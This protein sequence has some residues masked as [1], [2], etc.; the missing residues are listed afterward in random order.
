MD[1]FEWAHSSK[2]TM[3]SESSYGLNTPQLDMVEDEVDHKILDSDSK[4][5][6]PSLYLFVCGSE[7]KSAHMQLEF[8]TDCRTLETQ[9]VVLENAGSVAYHFEWFRDD[10]VADTDVLH[11][12]KDN[13]EQSCVHGVVHRTFISCMH[14]LLLPDECIEFT[15]F[16]RASTPGMYLEN[17]SLTLDPP[18]VREVHDSTNTK[19]PLKTS[20]SDQDYTILGV[21][22]CCI[23]VD[24]DVPIK[25]RQRLRD[26]IDGRATM[27]MAQQLIYQI[28]DSIKY[29]ESSGA[30]TAGST[31]A[32]V[33]FQTEHRN[34]PYESWYCYEDVANKAKSIN[35]AIRHLHEDIQIL[36]K[37]KNVLENVI[38]ENGRNVEGK[39]NFTDLGNKIAAT[40]KSLQSIAYFS[41][42]REGT[43]SDESSTEEEERSS[44]HESSTGSENKD[45]DE[46]L[47]HQRNLLHLEIAAKIR[48]DFESL[49]RE[50]MVSPDDREYF[51]RQLSNELSKVL[52]EVPVVDEIVK[53]SQYVGEEMTSSTSSHVYNGILAAVEK[54]VRSNRTHQLSRHTQLQRLQNGWPFEAS[55]FTNLVE[56]SIPHVV[57]NSTEGENAEILF[58]NVQL[59]T[60]LDIANWFG[61][62]HLQTD[63]KATS[64]AFSFQWKVN[65]ELANSEKYIPREFHSAATSICD[66]I[67][68]YQLRRDEQEKRHVAGSPL[69]LLV[70]SELSSPP[71]LNRQARREFD[72]A[73]A[74]GGYSTEVYVDALIATQDDH[75]SLEDCA[76]IFERALKRFLPRHIQ[77]TFQFCQTIEEVESIP[78]PMDRKSVQILLLQ[79]LHRLTSE[80]I[81]VDESNLGSFEPVGSHTGTNDL[82]H[83][84]SIRQRSSD[85][86]IFDT[87]PSKFDCLASVNDRFSEEEAALSPRAF[88]SSKLHEEWKLWLHS[89]TPQSVGCMETRNIAIIGGRNL[90]SKIHLIDT[91]IESSKEIYFVGKVAME[92]YCALFLRQ[93][94]LRS[95]ELI[96]EA[97]SRGRNKS[98]EKLRRRMECEETRDLDAVY[99]IPAVNRLQQKAYCRDTQLW[100]PRDW[101]VGEEPLPTHHQ[102]SLRDRVLIALEDD[103]VSSDGEGM[104]DE[105]SNDD[106]EA[107]KFKKSDDPVKSPPRSCA[108]E[109]FMTYEGETAHVV[110]SS[111]GSKSTKWISFGDV[112]EGFLCDQF[113]A[114]NESQAE[115]L[116]PKTQDE[117]DDSNTDRSIAPKK[118]VSPPRYEWIFRAYDVGP[119]SM[120]YLC[121]YLQEFCDTNDNFN[122]FINGVCGVVEYR[123]FSLATRQFLSTCSSLKEKYETINMFVA[124]HTTAKLLQWLDSKTSQ[125]EIHS[126][127]TIKHISQNVS[128]HSSISGNT[129]GAATIMKQILSG[130]T[131]HMITSLR[132]LHEAS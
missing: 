22:C 80:R 108:W 59:I 77:W 130:R 78:E 45:N 109:P 4:D 63:Q 42:D 5:F 12:L 10:I 54:A 74:S 112:T 66:I 37:D 90:S 72:M 33:H 93:R 92:L 116:E 23:A 16:F 44:D 36:E 91:M 27:R 60:D 86:I 126:C 94:H 81:N 32:D 125:S 67:Q 118:K 95:E 58:E 39:I 128:P 8:Y 50:A 131:N 40:E 119:Q 25:T 76:S 19:N 9:T 65:P 15:F 30:L 115:I 35:G 31:P 24:N 6:Q 49:V 117:E 103:I 20:T 14:G 106:D 120:D 29:G 71:M 83:E 89:L 105:D 11:H 124:G 52:S 70:M 53:L 17:W 61:L 68:W 55:H 46:S 85:T 18:L 100:L 3:Q 75:L 57:F 102:T 34:S 123:E 73:C 48:R 132:N 114:I 43:F 98:A 88:L 26:T 38:D 121:K 107:K 62:K 122:V 64:P 87:F 84:R 113:Q 99:M 69:R 110:I 28:L 129:I 97:Q 101:I 1:L 47:L 111:R 82:P 21:S 41:V 104:D 96:H 79:N 56:S 51:H 7:F 2:T 13:G 127:I